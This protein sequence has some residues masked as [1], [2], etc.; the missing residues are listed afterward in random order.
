[1]P[2]V[3]TLV[4]TTHKFFL[5]K[6]ATILGKVTDLLETLNSTVGARLNDAI[7][8]LDDMIVNR[9][10]AFLLVLQHF[11]QVLT[12]LEHLAGFGLNDLLLSCNG[13]YHDLIYIYSIK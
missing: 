9:L 2:R 8:D 4:T 5:F 3:V 1:M 7:D 6:Q 12:S 11:A 10:V 13:F